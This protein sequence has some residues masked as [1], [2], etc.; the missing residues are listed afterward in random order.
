MDS[1]MGGGSMIVDPRGRILEMVEED[2]G[3]IWADLDLDEV[4]QARISHTQY[5]DRR[6]DLYKTITAEM[7]DLHP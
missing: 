4:R 3:I 5:R 2:E 7:D 6:P 1:V